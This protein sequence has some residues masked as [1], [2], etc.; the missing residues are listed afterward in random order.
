MRARPALMHIRCPFPFT[1]QLDGNGLY[2]RLSLRV[3]LAQDII[4]LL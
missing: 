1:G 4:L 2:V 3:L